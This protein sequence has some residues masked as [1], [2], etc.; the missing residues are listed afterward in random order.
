LAV[1]QELPKRERRAPVALAAVE[2]VPASR[3]PGLQVLPQQGL[4]LQAQ[5]RA[6]WRQRMEADQQVFAEQHVQQL[7]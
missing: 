3:R 2:P 6:V 5:E 1:P 4:V 7:P